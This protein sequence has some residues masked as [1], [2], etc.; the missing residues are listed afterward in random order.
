MEMIND[1][2][3]IS[4]N[5]MKPLRLISFSSFPTISSFHPFRPFHPIYSFLSFPFCPFALFD[6]FFALIQLKITVSG[7]F[8]FLHMSRPFLI[9][10][11]ENKSNQ[12]CLA[13]EITEVT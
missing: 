9:F 5:E 6:P 1:Q 12:S 2:N 7:L 3:L 10:N 11:L 4:Q 13:Y 8:S